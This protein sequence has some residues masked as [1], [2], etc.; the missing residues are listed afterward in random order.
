MLTGWPL[1]ITIFFAILF[2]V[3]ACTKWKLHPFLALLIATIATGLAVGLP[4]TDIA[5]TAADGF[6]QM[7]TH[8]G[9]VVILGTLIGTVLEKTG[10]TLRIAD[11]IISL[12]GKDKP[13]IAITIIGVVVGIP[14]FCDSGYVIL[15]GLT[16]PLAKESGKSY[17]AI[18][19]GLSGG[20]YITHTL[21]PPHPGSLAGAANLGVGGHLGVVIMMGLIISIPVAIVTG[22]FANKF[23]SRFNVPLEDDEIIEKGNVELPSLTKSLLPVIVPVLLI[24]LGSLAAIMHL[25][26]QLNR[27]LQFIGS[28]LIALLIGLALSLLLIKKQERS[29]FERWMKEGAAHAGPIL[30]LV[31]AG[32]VFGN[33]LKKTPLA[34]MVQQWVSNDA[35]LSHISILLIAFAIGA[36]LKT[37]Q[38]STTSAIIIATSI[39]GPI[40][41]VA[42]FDRPIELSLLL[43]AT[44]AGA[45]MISHANDAYFWVISQFSGLNM[46]Q[47]YR[48]FSLSTIVMGVTTILVVLLISLFVF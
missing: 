37:A 31:G 18:V 33:L 40:A 34:D 25:P 7:M 41:P 27:W 4:I 28:P 11:S 46:Q 10:A 39:L 20:L 19:G 15:S 12:F 32:G 23:T 8:I 21:L 48:T 29:S 35:S 30:I 2:I 5:K 3:V 38:G 44:A 17:P 24:A 9:L 45:M 6:G 14:I 22:L 36:L 43:S 13:V 26:E 16:R 47:T 1:L 42:G